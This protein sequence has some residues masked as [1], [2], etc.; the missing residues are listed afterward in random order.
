ML[1]EIFFRG[2][3]V[4]AFFVISGFSLSL[5]YYR[6]LETN[7]DKVGSVLSSSSFRR[8]FRLFIPSLVAGLISYLFYETGAYGPSLQVLNWKKELPTVPKLD[9]EW[10]QRGMPASRLENTTYSERA[11]IFV[12]DITYKMWIPFYFSP[13][14]GALWTMAFELLG[15][16]LLIW[17]LLAVMLIKPGLRRAFFMVICLV[18][19][20]VP[21]Y[22]AK[23][24]AEF[25]AGTLL[26]DAW[27]HQKKNLSVPYSAWRYYARAISTW[28]SFGISLYLLSVSDQDPLVDSR[29]SWLNSL[30]KPFQTNWTSHYLGSILVVYSVQINPALQSF[31]GSTFMLFLGRLSIGLYLLHYVFFYSLISWLYLFMKTWNPWAA[32]FTL[33]PLLFLVTGIASYVFVRFIDEPSGILVRNLEKK[34]AS[35][36]F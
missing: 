13:F 29:Y 3:S 35:S 1:F 32:F 31:F 9:L 23:Y 28:I 11:L 15:S 20:C 21:S 30:L 14:N 24:L 19:F 27:V 17:I 4:G 6:Y 22:V 33:L 25:F 18:G 2:V 12:E 26:A 5:K 34:V 36:K 16:V 8:W 7:P 10:F